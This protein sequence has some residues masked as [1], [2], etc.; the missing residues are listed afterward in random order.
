VPEPEEN[1]IYIVDRR[2]KSFGETK[3]QMAGMLFHFSQ[4]SRRQRIELRNKTE[5]LSY[6]L[7]WKLLGKFYFKARRQALQQ[8]YG[9]EIPMPSFFAQPEELGV[10]VAE[11]TGASF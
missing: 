2:H 11:E 9:I 4:L 7:D 10:D 8:V 6:L 1:G 3:D 5:S